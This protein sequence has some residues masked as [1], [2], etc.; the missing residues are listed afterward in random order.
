[1]RFVITI[2]SVVTLVGLAGAAKSQEAMDIGPAD[3]P[4]W[5]G[6]T[7]DGVASPK[8]MPPL[9]WSEKENVLWKVHVPGRGHGSPIVVGDQ[10]FLATAEA[11][12]DSQS[13]VC[14]DRNTGEKRWQTDVHK[15][16]LNKGGNEKASLASSTPACDGKRVFINFWNGKGIYTTAVDREGKQLWQTKVADYTL[17]QGFGSSPALHKNV[18]LV[19]AD[20]KGGTGVVAGLDRASGD[21]IWSRPRP[22][23]PNYASPIVFHIAGKDQLLLQGCKLVTSLNPA[24]GEQ[25]W[26]IEGSTEECVTSPVAVGDI[27]LVS[28]GYPKNHVAAVKADGSGKVVWE[29]KQRVYVPSMLA[30]DGHFYAVLDSGQA[31]CWKAD[32]GAELWKGRV[33]G[34]FSASLV[35]IGDTILATNEAGRSHLFK[36]TP[37]KFTPVGEN[38]LGNSALASPAVCGGRIYMRVAE[39]KGKTRQEWLYCLGSK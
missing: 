1:M 31:I 16:G 4:W 14:F 23:W 38:Q 33:E 39:Q 3:W 28:G 20:T 34:T 29:N 25:L 9:T 6:P 32:T 30:H 12:R 19:T 2:V 27:F 7:R 13:L 24:T 26:E 10:V 22:K 5:R 37:E 36:A 11:D 8:Q 15:G 18:C 17:H 35:L 21:I